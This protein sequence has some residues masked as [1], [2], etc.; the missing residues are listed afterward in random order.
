[1][2]QLRRRNLSYIKILGLV[3]LFCG[4]L[5]AQQSSSNPI[6]VDGVAAVVGENI[7]LE[8]D[9][10]KFK[11]ELEQ[12]SKGTNQ[13]GQCE[14]LEDI[15]LQKLMSHQA[16]QDSIVVTDS[17]VLSQ[18]ESNIQYLVSSL[19]E[20]S[21]VIDFYG[22]NDESDLREELMNVQKESI[23]VQ[24]MQAKI[25]ENITVTPEEVRLYFTSLENS[26]ALPEFSSE[27]VLAQIVLN[28]T[29]TDEAIQET[30]D[31]LNQIRQE[32]ID[33]ASFR[34]RAIMN[35]D[36]PAVT[37]NG[38]QYEIERSSAF[39]KEFKEA[40]FS[41]DVGEVSE[42]FKSQFGYHIL[43]V[44]QI[45][46]Q[47][48]VARH[49]LL[50][51]KVS[52][53]DLNETKQSLNSIRTDIL[54]DKITFEEGVAEYSEDDNTKLSGGVLRNPMT[55]EFSFDLTKM[56]PTLYARISNLDQ[57]EMTDVFYD[58]TR[59]G[60][61]MFK[62]I[63]MKDKVPSHIADLKQDYVKIQKLA[64]Q[65]KQ[66]EEIDTWAADKII[67]TY[68]KLGNDHKSCSFEN[69]WTKTK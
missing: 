37:Q 64:L 49:I 20:M 40:A 38:G 6:K 17:E 7:V 48:V 14:M 19:G 25:T 60:E 21:K 63:Y 29:P 16:V 58:E 61:K 5:N 13:I 57:G 18:V 11:K 67:D 30:T 36:D 23:L 15:M 69:N 52:T 3:L 27:V 65:K 32:V 55:R 43:Q 34:M 39:V 33:G 54:L 2:M 41:L 59:E 44:E 24:R 50:Q 68:I 42:I 62:I 31:R 47:K 28:V 12:R 51:P 10:T 4:N 35:S 53:K 9:I 26:D 8:S 1:M 46:G 45:K 56:D 66:E 22:F